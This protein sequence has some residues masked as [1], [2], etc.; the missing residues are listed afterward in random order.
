MSR[1]YKLKKFLR[2]LNEDLLKEFLEKQGI[3]GK[4]P[5]KEPQ[6]IYWERVITGLPQINQIEA[7][8]RDINDL[9]T[10]NGILS[11]LEIGSKNINELPA[12]IENIPNFY[13]Q[14]LY[15]YMTYPNIFK[16]T[17]AISYISDLKIKAERTGLK[18]CTA[19]EVMS[20]KDDLQY[21]IQEYLLKNDGRGRNCH[22][23]V[24][25]DEDNVYFIAYP[26]DYVKPDLHYDENGNFKKATRKPTFEIVYKYYPKTGTLQLN[27]KGRKKRQLA[28]FNIFNSVVLDSDKPVLENQVIY[29]LNKLLDPEFIL[30]TKLEDSIEEIRVKQL[31][32]TDKYDNAK[33]VT[34]EMN[35]PGGL[36]PIQEHIKQL[37]IDI[38]TINVTQALI[39]LKF[40]GN[41][42]RGGVTMQLTAP[43][44]CN[45]NDSY[46]HQKAKAY[47]SHWGLD[48]SETN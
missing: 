31:R 46:L 10:E 9:A 42:K 8:F 22:L 3:D 27:T 5:E 36:K 24:Y 47:I 7:I 30:T 14:A 25:S 13:N 32:L 19:K 37:S 16:N 23:D 12:E 18:Q 43:D 26:E 29:D 28:L 35:T 40:P 39:N 44:K 45:L 20:K 34:I 11:L 17:H 41:G 38:K 1:T 48:N 21:A 33:R 6:E 15:I 4:F 2:H